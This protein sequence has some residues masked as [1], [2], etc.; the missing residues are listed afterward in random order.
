MVRLEILVLKENKVSKVKQDQLEQREILVL[1]VLQE[2]KAQLVQ[3]V[4]REM[5]VLKV[6]LAHRVLLEK[7]VAQELKEK[8]A[9]KAKLVREH[10]ALS[11]VSLTIQIR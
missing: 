11:K 1:T 9:Q 2:H 10:S 5:R 3:M 8:L 7:W 4:K 6:K